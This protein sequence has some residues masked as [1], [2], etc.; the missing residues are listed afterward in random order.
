MMMTE[1]MVLI[2]STGDRVTQAQY[3]DG[4]VTAANQ[5][6]TVIDFD[7]HGSRRFATP[8]VRLE[9]S[10]TVA[11]AKPAKARRARRAAAA[12]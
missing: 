4:T 9:R 1:E 6:H 7:A 3:G 12:L 5:Y 8:L 10:F 2:Y 11:P